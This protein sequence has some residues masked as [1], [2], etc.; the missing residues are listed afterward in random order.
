MKRPGPERPV[1]V[2]ALLAV[3]LTAGCTQWHY[4]LG[5]PL[6]PETHPDPRRTTT[7]ARV[8][9]DLGPPQRVSAISNGYVLAWEFWRIKEEKIGLSLGLV[10]T[11]LLSVDWGQA[12]IKGE[13]LLVTFNRQHLVTS[14]TFGNWDNSGGTGAALQ[15]PLGPFS[16]VD[17][18]DLVTR[19]PHH[20]W[21]GSLLK[22][23]PQA[24]NSGSRPDMG[25][26]GIQ[27]RGTPSGTGQQSL[28][29]DVR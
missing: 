3:C 4:D 29:I 21:G 2:A 15:P 24:I 14:S 19:M 11:D 1:L 20:Q 13:F 25:Q 18:D 26:A 23:I 17:V 16:V 9:S 10:G 12:R 7:L 28:E 5:H 6:T 27:Q 8:L 22:P